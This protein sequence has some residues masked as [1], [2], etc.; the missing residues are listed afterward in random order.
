[1]VSYQA[2]AL[3]RALATD[4][5]DELRAGIA[6]ARRLGMRASLSPMFDPDYSQLPWWNASS[7]GPTGARQYHRPCAQQCVGKYQSCMVT[8]G[9]F[10]PSPRTRTED[11]SLAGGGLGRGKWGNGWSPEQVSA[12]FAEYLAP[13]NKSLAASKNSENDTFDCN[14]IYILISAQLHGWIRA[15]LFL[16]VGTGRSS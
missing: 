14:V 16:G 15:H 10:I 1:M 3:P 8:R 5:D 7:G 13:R 2:T 6:A 4:T 9:R 12:W 11:K